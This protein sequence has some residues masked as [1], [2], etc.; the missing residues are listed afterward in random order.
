MDP[1]RWNSGVSVLLVDN[2]V[3][4][5]EISSSWSLFGPKGMG[6]SLSEAIDAYGEPTDLILGYGCGGDLA[7]LYIY[8]VYPE[9]GTVVAAQT[10]EQPPVIHVEPELYVRSV[11]F[12][13]PED[14]DVYLGEENSKFSMDCLRSSFSSPW[15]GFVALQFPDSMSA[16]ED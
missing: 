9:I 5:I 7:C 14:T 3:S 6:L 10:F 4:R 12:M 8:L 11:A 16:C 2:V 1:R 13:P 15:Q